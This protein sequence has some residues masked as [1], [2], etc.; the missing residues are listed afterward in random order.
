M[1]CKHF[2]ERGF[3]IFTPNHGVRYN[4]TVKVVDISLPNIHTQAEMLE[5][6][7]INYS[8]CAAVV[9]T[10]E[11]LRAIGHFCCNSEN[12]TLQKY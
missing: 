11:I 1:N 3:K 12:D 5:I 9:K 2:Y 10:A 6:L 4:A 8:I 7:R